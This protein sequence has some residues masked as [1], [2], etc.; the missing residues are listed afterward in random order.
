MSG[1]ASPL[2]FQSLHLIFVTRNT[3]ITKADTKQKCIRI[4]SLG[5][6]ITHLQMISMRVQISGVGLQNI[7]NLGITLLRE[8]TGDESDDIKI[9]GM[10]L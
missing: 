3:E 7:H 5:V 9:W 1:T 2:H 4:H 8:G 10:N 6:D